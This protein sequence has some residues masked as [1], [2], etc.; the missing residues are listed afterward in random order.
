VPTGVAAAALV[1]LKGGMLV[2]TGSATMPITFTSVL[3]ESALVSLA[4]ASTDSNE[5]A[6]TLGEHGKWGGLILLGNAPTNVATTTQIE[7]ITGYTY[8][9]TYCGSS[10]WC[11]LRLYLV[12]PRFALLRLGWPLT[13]SD[14][15]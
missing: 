7:G 5:N 14:G 12:R 9:Y 15:L 3:A 1:V 4:T 8:C 2:A 10:I 13:A 6:I 11:R